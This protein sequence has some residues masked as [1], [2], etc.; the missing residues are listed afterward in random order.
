MILYQYSRWNLCTASGRCSKRTTK[1][2]DHVQCV[3]Q[4]PR[5]ICRTKRFAITVTYSLSVNAAD[6]ANIVHVQVHNVFLVP[7]LCEGVNN[8]SQ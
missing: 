4:T 6:K 3:S 8:D 7:Q 2:C 5:S 1:D